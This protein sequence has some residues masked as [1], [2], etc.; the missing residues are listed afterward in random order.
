[1]TY[2]QTYKDWKFL[3]DIDP[4][5]DM[6]GGYVDSEDLEELLKNPTKKTAKRCLSRQI[7]Y[8]F[9]VGIQKGFENETTMPSEL[10]DEYPEISEIAERHFIDF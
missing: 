5:Y 3:F 6:T 7:N 8:W 10:V 9:D 4:A 1:M 2:E